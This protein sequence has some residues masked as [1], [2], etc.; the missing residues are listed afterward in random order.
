MIP[1]YM[2]ILP[3]NTS[4]TNICFVTF[5]HNFPTFCR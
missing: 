3:L 2:V 4:L 5:S 1:S